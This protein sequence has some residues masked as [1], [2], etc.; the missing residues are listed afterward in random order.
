MSS[1]CLIYAR[2]LLFFLLHFQLME[3]FG[4]LVVTP[5]PGR[6]LLLLIT[7]RVPRLERAVVE[8]L[9]TTFVTFSGDS[10]SFS[11]TF[12]LIRPDRTMLF[13]GIVLER[14]FLR[15]ILI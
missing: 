11:V 12:S 6:A 15:N 13:I 7:D 4:I 10:D 1:T 14:G 3:F 2:R 5:R 9:S 8:T